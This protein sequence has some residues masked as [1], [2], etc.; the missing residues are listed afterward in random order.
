MKLEYPKKSQTIINNYWWIT[1]IGE[2][3]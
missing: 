3:Y 1:I 2:L